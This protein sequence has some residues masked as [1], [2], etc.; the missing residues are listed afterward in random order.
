MLERAGRSFQFPFKPE[1]QDIFHVKQ[2]LFTKLQ[3]LDEEP[4]TVLITSR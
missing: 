4:H 3:A 1:L 2:R